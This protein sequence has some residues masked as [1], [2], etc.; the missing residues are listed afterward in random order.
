MKFTKTEKRSAT[1]TNKLR[2]IILQLIVNLCQLYDS[3]F[4]I[5]FVWP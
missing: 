3:L 4:I 1:V 5:S 2:D